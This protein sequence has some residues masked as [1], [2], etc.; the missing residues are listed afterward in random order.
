LNAKRS[1]KAKPGLPVAPLPALMEWWRTEQIK[2]VIIG[3]LAVV[4]LGR[5]R[6]LR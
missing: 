3:G 1:K 6:H 2:G 5:P 4:L